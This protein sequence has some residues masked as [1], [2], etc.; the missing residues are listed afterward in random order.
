MIVDKA[1]AE[2]ILLI[3]L[4]KCAHY[5]TFQPVIESRGSI[6]NNT[7]IIDEVLSE[8]GAV[9]IELQCLSIQELDKTQSKPVARPLAAQGLLEKIRQQRVFGCLGCVQRLFTVHL[10]RRNSFKQHGNLSSIF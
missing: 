3:R 7:T 1:Q 2:V 9:S 6:N 5:R 4:Q 8:R 10:K